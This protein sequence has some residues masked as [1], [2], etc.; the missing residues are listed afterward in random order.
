MNRVGDWLPKDHRILRDW[1]Q[2]TIRASDSRD[3]QELHPTVH[4]FWYAIRSDVRLSMLFDSMFSEVPAKKPYRY[5]TAGHHQIKDYG[6]L[7]QVLNYLLS[8]APEWAHRD[9]AAGTVGLPFNAMFDWPM[10]TPSGWAVFLDP[11]VNQHL[12]AILNAW[13]SYLQSPS[14]ANVLGTGK[15]G[16]LGPEGKKELT[17]VANEASGT[18]HTFEEM[19]ICNPDEQY[20]GFTSWDNFFTR[21]YRD[22]VRPVANPENDDVL[23]NAC[24]SKPYRVARNISAG[25]KFWV[26]GQPYS[27]FTMLAQDELAEHFVGGTVY[28]AFLSALSY[29]RW[30]SPV[31]GRIVKQYV[32]SGTYFSE[33]LFTGMADPHG[34]DPFGEGTGQ[35]YL[36]SVATRAIIFIEADNPKIGLI[37]V[38]PIG[39]VEVS[40]CEVIVKE[41]QRVQKGEELGMVSITILCQLSEHAT[42]GQ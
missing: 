12:K 21:Q 6:H 30:H 24:E 27:V 38:M 40:T 3:K 2:D 19:F 17:R 9:Y 10:G 23:A 25:D 29:H 14:S 16:W 41:G 13:G 26:K 39:M 11:I 42:D 36:S 34:A 20:H 7:C 35:A 33:P 8:A 18:S 28:Q 22:N 32:V 31:S 1:L 4:A 5:D 37:C 15:Q